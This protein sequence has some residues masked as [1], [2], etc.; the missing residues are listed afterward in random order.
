MTVSQHAGRGHEWTRSVNQSSRWARLSGYGIIALLI[1]GFGYWASTVP[2]G[3]AVIAPG[4]VAAAGQNIQIQH[5]EGGI[6]RAINVREGNLVKTGDSLI[7]LND[8][9]ASVNLNRVEKQVMGLKARLL[10]LRAERDGKQQ[11]SVPDTLA[12]KADPAFVEALDEQVSEFNVRLERYQSELTIMKQRAGALETNMA[13]YEARKNSFDSQLR[14]V[15]EEMERKK[16][17]LDKGLTNRSEYSAL[18]R[19]EAD[20]SGKLGELEASI[21]GTRIQMVEAREQI[22]R[23][24]SQRVE[25]AVAALTEGRLKLDDLEEQ[26]NG[27]RDVLKRTVIRSPVD[28]AIVRMQ[29]NSAGSVVAPGQPLL[30]ILPTSGDLVIEA[31]VNPRDIDAVKLG[32]K[33]MLRFS[34]LN[35]RTTPQMLG[36]VTYVSADRIIDQKDQGSYFI[37]RLKLDDGAPSLITEE[38]F[39]PG[40]PVETYISTEDRTFFEYLLKPLEDSIN[41]AFR[42]E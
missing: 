4:V 26:V 21:A 20:L 2:L 34:A 41:R 22:E 14:V 37:A 27:A 15:E 5:L 12:E 38:Q 13:G 17:L 42:E 8:T 16:V 31:R 1:A 6:V 29:I 24:T 18:L 7:V 33:A 39:Y 28:G 35:A 30:E 25:E 11:I 36:V 40:M 9:S 23:V 19:T 32:Q 10:R 3:G